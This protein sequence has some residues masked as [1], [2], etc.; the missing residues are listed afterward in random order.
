MKPRMI[1]IL[2]IVLI[3]LLLSRCLVLSV[4]PLYFDKDLMFE[5]DL[6]GTWGEKQYEKDLSELWIFKKSGENSYSLIVKEKEEGEG[7]FETHLLKLGKYMFL[8][9][10][11]EEPEGGM[12]FYNMHLI[13]THSFLRISLEG[14]VLRM[15]FFD[16]DWLKKNLEQGNIEITHERRD[17]VIVLTASTKE[18]QEFVLEHVEEAFP[19]EKEVLHRFW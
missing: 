10:Y 5:P 11:P 3:V 8:D 12:E 4:H 1:L 17:D 6:V 18:L 19:F 7:I 9:L 16:L 13:P 2:F 15:G 14:H